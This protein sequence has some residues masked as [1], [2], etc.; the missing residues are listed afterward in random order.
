MSSD[1]NLLCFRALL[2]A[3]ACCLHVRQEGCQWDAAAPDGETA[4]GRQ[5]GEVTPGTRELN[6]LISLAQLGLNHTQY[7]YDVLE[8]DIYRTG[9]CLSFMFMFFTKTPTDTGIVTYRC[10]VQSW[11]R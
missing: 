9:E 10:W 1:R 2:L 4:A 11:D 7:L 5:Q 8:P 6:T 3:C